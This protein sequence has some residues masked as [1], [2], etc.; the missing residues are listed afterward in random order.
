MASTVGDPTVIPRLVANHI[1]TTANTYAGQTGLPAI[2]VDLEFLTNAV[3][4]VT[5]ETQTL[6]CALLQVTLIDPAWKI[7]RSG[8]CSTDQAGML[9]QVD[10][11]YP[12][13]TPVWWRLAEVQ[14]ASADAQPG[15]P[16]LTMTFQ[17]RPWVYL[18]QC[19]GAIGWSGLT[20]KPGTTLAQFVKALCDKMPS[21]LPASKI[22]PG[23]APGIT[24]ICPQLNQ[25][26]PVASSNAYGTE[27]VTSQNAAAQAAGVNKLSGVT[28]ATQVTVKGSKPTPTQLTLINQVMG[29][30]A[31]LKAPLLAQ[32]A[33]LEACIQENDFTNNPGGG[34]G[35]NGLLQ[36]IPSTAA[37]AGISPLDV[38][39]CVTAFLTNGYNPHGGTGAIGYA[40]A[41]PSW[42]ADQVAQAVQA[43]GAGASF[44]AQWLTEA[45]NIIQAFD[46]GLSA[47]GGV[48]AAPQ[49]DVDQLTRGT[50]DN[51]D[52]DSATC[53][54]RLAAGVNWMFFSDPQPH[55]GI[56]GDYFYFI[57]GP[58][59]AA[60]R[61]SM[62]L[63]LSDDGTAWSM[64]DPTTGKTLA[65]QGTVTS[66]QGSI[67]NTAFL[68]EQTTTL[69]AQVGKGKTSTGVKKATRIA[70]P[71]TPSQMMFD[72]LVGVLELNAGSVVV[73]R[74]AGPADGRW[75]VEDVTQ[76]SIQD[77]FA[78][79]T[80]GPPTFPYPEPQ[81]STVTA[82]AA[83]GQG[84][85]GSATGA[86]GSPAAPASAANIQQGA[87]VGV[88][89]AALLALK[90]QQASGGS[91]YLYSEQS[92]RGNNGTL[93]GPAPR[94]MDCSSFS[95]LC[96]Q[97][98]GLPDPNHQGYSPI[99]NT[100]SF[101]AHCSNISQGDALP[102]DV[103]FFGADA[104][105]TVHMNVF[106]GNGQC[107][108]MGAPGE[109]TLDAV[110][111]GPSTFLG[112][113]RSDVVTAAQAAG[114][115][116]AGAA[117]TVGAAAA[118]A[119]AVTTVV[120]GVFQSIFDWKG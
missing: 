55:P 23:P 43:S 39:G 36:L 12:E 79:V 96:Y 19:F 113:Y 61:P 115:A 3:Q 20:G 114:G 68:F 102:G 99:G 80:C 15:Q 108:N 42:S 30:A 60:Q 84:G 45:N 59:C 33:L 18:M 58:T 41:H 64:T 31:G 35:S 118:A 40:Q 94:T 21:E 14:F 97:A 82:A 7:L 116:V 27:V 100:A 57:D 49:S 107:V 46:G 2:T 26:Q 104:S 89:Q 4:E 9:Y 65:A 54:Q 109:P 8:I 50:P 73:C 56:W 111:T 47:A 83:T 86:A 87:L 120:G 62:Y 85:V 34:G 5:P 106:V 112:F 11:N 98:A 32:Q 70:T 101:I 90:Q 91:L 69:A 52:E 119:S 76:N 75:I 28:A 38:N 72:I 13:G 29:I 1:L 88:A 77:L 81:A 16:N 24:L 93:F 22:G 78:Q 25:I 95:T 103:C 44:Y 66:L 74:N 48:S 92:N 71:Q 67:D 117:T 37:Q 10:V 105:H 110:G 53:I 6:G 51:V 63:T 17:H